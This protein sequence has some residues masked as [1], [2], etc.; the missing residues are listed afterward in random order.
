M[1]KKILIFFTKKF[2]NVYNF[3]CKLFDISTYILFLKEFE[4]IKSNIIKNK[5]KFL[6][7][8]RKKININEKTFNKDIKNCLDNQNFSIL[9]M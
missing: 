5:N 2:I 6:F 9:G 7:E 3:I 1:Y 8:K 4:I